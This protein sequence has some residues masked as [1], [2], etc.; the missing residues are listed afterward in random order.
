MW[1]RRG[2][3]WRRVREGFVFSVLE[4]MANLFPDTIHE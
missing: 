4:R 2:Q 3:S 1:R